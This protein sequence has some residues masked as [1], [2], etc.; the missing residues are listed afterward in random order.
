MKK[1]SRKEK[2]YLMI[3]DGFGEGKNYKGNAIKKAHMPYLNKLKREYPST[4]LKASGNEVGLPRGAM[5]NSEVGHY[6]MGA[7]RIVFQAYEEI[8]QSIKD[9]SFFRKK[10][11]LDAIKKAKKNKSA[12]HLLGMISDEGVH[13][14][15]NHL[16]ALLELVKKH[17]VNKVY[18]HAITDGRDVAERSA[19]KYIKKIQNKIKQLDL[20]KTTKIA[21]II[22]R[23]Y[24]MDRDHNWKRTKKAYDLYTL[25]KGTKE[26]DPL[27]AIK[28]AYQRGADTDYYIDPIVLDENC[29]ITSKD[30]VI[31]YN[32]RTDRPR[33]L[34]HCFTKEEKIG[35]K[36]TKNVKP[37]L[38][39]FGEYTETAPVVFPPPKIKNNLSQTLSKTGKKQLHIAETEKYAHV[40]FFFNSQE[41]DPYKGET[42][43]MVNSPKVASYDEK[44]E[45]SAFELTNK[46]VKELDKHEY[47][48]V[49]QNFANLDL[50]G[51]SG[52]LEATVKACEAI[53]KCIGKIYPITLEK[54][55]HLMITGDHGNAEYMIYEDTKEQCPSHTT[56]PVPFILVSK[57][58]KNVRLC[59]KSGLKDIAPTI[60]KIMGIKKPKEMTGKSLIRNGK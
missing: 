34:T 56:N 9:K 50:V 1:N 13:S 7:G 49:I 40:T 32:F 60:L 17:K 39:C 20:E 3:L 4:L 37:F 52:E 35:F 23:F 18:I 16:F 2:V 26:E 51:H 29:T 55:Y 57:T 14:H 41:E 6:T 28:N 42:R 8:N 44:P 31:F 46:I 43:I 30:S 58:I 36:Q 54:G 19:D 25:A 33:Q 27:K 45:M 15:I 11:I 24:A 10:P 47:D 48:I 21:S 38:V 5:G 59:K 53:D 22:G 12:L